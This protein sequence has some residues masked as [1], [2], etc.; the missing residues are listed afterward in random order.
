[1]PRTR[2][3]PNCRREK[4]ASPPR[5]RS[6]SAATSRKCIRASKA[7]RSEELRD[8]RD[9][10]PEMTMKRSVA[11]M[12]AAGVDQPLRNVTVTAWQHSFCRHTQ[13]GDT[14][15][16]DDAGRYR[17]DYDVEPSAAGD[18]V[19]NLVVVAHD[20]KGGELARSPVI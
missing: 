8:V 10:Q 19:V 5:W 2:R 15:I 7:S 9:A 3:T 18:V 4:S 11:G 14:T 1:M 16:T 12:V 6:D 20:T 13:L 17:I